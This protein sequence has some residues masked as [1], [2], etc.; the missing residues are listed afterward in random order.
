MNQ[1]YYQYAEKF[2]LSFG[3]TVI[4]GII[5]NTDTILGDGYLSFEYSLS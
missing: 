4:T 3:L 1:F 2:L 5:D